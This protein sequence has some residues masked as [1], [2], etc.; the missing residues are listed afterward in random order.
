MYGWLD[1]VV[2]YSTELFL[3]GKLGTELQCTALVLNNSLL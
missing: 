1:V 2:D 3:K